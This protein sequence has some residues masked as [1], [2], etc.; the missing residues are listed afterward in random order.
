MANTVN[1]GD[2]KKHSHYTGQN[3]HSGGYSPRGRGQSQRGGYGYRGR[4]RSGRGGNWNPGNKPQCQ[5]CGKFGH[6]VVDCY[7]RF[8]QSFKVSGASDSSSQQQGMPHGQGRGAFSSHAMAAM[9]ATPETVADPNWYPDSG[10][11]NHVTSEP[12]NLVT[13]QEYFGPDQVQVGNGKGLL[14]K[15]VGSASFCSP[16]SSRIMNLKNLLHV[17]EITKNLLSV[18]KFCVDNNVFF[19]FHAFSCFVKDQISKSILLEGKLDNGLYVFD[20]DQLRISS[21]PAASTSV[22]SIAPRNSFAFVVSN[23]AN[24]NVYTLWHN[25]LGH[26]SSR[27]VKTVLSSCNIHVK[28][29]SDFEFCTSCCL[30]KI[31]KFPFSHSSTVYTLPLEMIYTDLWGPAPIHSKNGYTYYI[32]FVDA[33]T[34]FTWLYLLKHKSD[35]LETFKLFKTQVELQLGYKIKSL[36]SDYGGE[37]RSFKGFLSQCG[38]VHR[39]PCPHVHEQNGTVERKHRHIVENGLTLLAQASLP[40]KYWDEA[41]RTAVYIHN[42]LP[43]PILNSKTPIELLYKTKPDYSLLKTFGC[44]CFPNLRPYNKHKLQ[45]RS[46]ECIFLGYSLNHKGYK[47]MDPTG[48]LYISRDVIFNE[49]HFPYKLMFPTSKVISP[50]P[51]NSFYP[52]SI[53]CIPSINSGIVNMEQNSGINQC[54]N[55][56]PCLHE[57]LDPNLVILI[58]IWS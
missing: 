8:D 4:G 22:S 2:K 56:L 42:R 31:H 25:R 44:S 17:P 33:S 3:P 30:G 37:F 57:H 52:N 34:R 20:R 51:T 27:I 47:C 18:S 54:A 10:A 14:I 28:D 45:F 6:V 43:T 32:S 24:Q 40:L 55:D 11:S 35:A 23:N 36:Q 13:K 9:L 15:H 19:E 29:K 16:Y 48:R 50:T 21:Q 1:S 7:Y 58:L 41:Y 5:L 12:G 39:H 38:I 53:P 26:P 46:T 49:S